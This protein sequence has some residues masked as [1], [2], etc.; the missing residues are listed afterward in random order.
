MS[1]VQLSGRGLFSGTA[2][3]RALITSEAISGWGGVD[4]KTGQIIESG[5]ELYGQ[6]FSGKIFVFPGAK[7]SSGWSGTFHLARL[8]GSAPKALI[9]NSMSTKV[10]LGVVVTRVPAVTEL[11]RD[12]IEAI[13]TGDWV[14]VDGTRGLVIVRKEQHQASPTA[15]AR[16][17]RQPQD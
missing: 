12:P 5:H 17:H 3:G 7:G 6:S 15:D 16:S 4:A 14:L 1:E 8:A 13:E 10:A 2:E 9:F 11:D